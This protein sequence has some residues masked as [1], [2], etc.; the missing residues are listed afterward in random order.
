MLYYRYMRKLLSKLIE[1]LETFIFHQITQ[2]LMQIFAK[3]GLSK[4]IQL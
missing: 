3:I 2:M 4:I 1:N